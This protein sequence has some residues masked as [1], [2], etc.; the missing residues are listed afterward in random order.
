MSP[1]NKTKCKF[2]DA[3]GKCLFWI[4]HYSNVDCNISK[5]RKRK[6]K[7]KIKSNWGYIWKKV[8]PVFC[9]PCSL[10]RTALNRNSEDKP[11]TLGSL[12]NLEHH[13]MTRNVSAVLNRRIWRP[14][15]KS[16]YCVTNKT[17]T[18][19][20]G[21]LYIPELKSLLIWIQTSW[22]EHF[23]RLIY[24]WDFWCIYFLFYF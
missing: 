21:I 19:Q 12:W 18:C 8:H 6:V 2:E 5:K 15:K 17:F 24:K 1:R 4:M 9:R 13:N 3:F 11:R 22:I 10:W 20:F 16:L 14:K 23:E 7:W